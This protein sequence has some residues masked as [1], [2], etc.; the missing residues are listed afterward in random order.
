MIKLS[1][2]HYWRQLGLMSDPFPEAMPLALYYTERW[3][4]YLDFL[5]HTDQYRKSLLLVVG[6]AGVGKTILVNKAYQS[7]QNQAKIIKLAASSTLRPENLLTSLAREFHAL[8]LQS[9]PRIDLAAETFLSSL[10]KTDKQYFV[11]IDNADLLPVETLELCLYLVKHQV[12]TQTSLQLVLVGSLNLQTQFTKILRSKKETL[13]EYLL[14][15]LSVQP[16]SKEE[17]AHYIKDQLKHAGDTGRIT[18]FSVAEIEKIYRDSQ[19]LPAGIQAA[20]RAC[21]QQLVEPKRSFSNFFSSVLNQQRRRLF[22]WLLL[23]VLI[24]FF[25]LWRSVPHWAEKFSWPHFLTGQAEN[26]VELKASSLPENNENAQETTETYAPGSHIIVNGKMHTVGE[27]QSPLPHE[28]AEEAK[29]V[30]PPGKKIIT[31]IKTEDLVPRKEPVSQKAHTLEEREKIIING[32]IQ[33]LPVLLGQTPSKRVILDSTADP[34]ASLNPIEKK[35]LEAN[36]QYFTVQLFI[37]NDIAQAQDF[38]RQN[39]LINQAIVY[40]TLR[41]G[42]LLYVV[43]L[44]D[45]PSRRAANNAIATLSPAVQK[46][47]PWP[48]SFL[49]VHQDI[50]T[51]EK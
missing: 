39:T 9:Q 48:R 13:Q 28:V 29:P 41:Q 2:V 38:I 21:L 35:L 40:R 19:G 22:L 1:S 33:E 11:V 37:S 45:F 23:I 5:L 44:G 31:K 46:L 14:Q 25:M 34:L 12:I 6:E 3:Q 17:V 32:E 16:F 50:M 51:R 27:S 30:I 26:K 10:H 43:I 36:E 49:S 7:L 24:V 20:A 4:Q 15:I 8:A 18:F 47:N 42:E